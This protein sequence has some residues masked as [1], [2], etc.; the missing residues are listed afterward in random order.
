MEVSPYHSAKESE[1]HYHNN[2]E[3][4]AGNLIPL[5]DLAPGKRWDQTLCPTCAQL[6]RAAE[7]QSSQQQKG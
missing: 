3:C 6:N 2:N 4:S 5:R 7:S 1:R